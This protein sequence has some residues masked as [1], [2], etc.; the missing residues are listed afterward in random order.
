MLHR[1]SE[2]GEFWQGVSGGVE[3][4]ETLEAAARRELIEETSLR[5]VELRQ[6]NCSYTFAMQEDWKRW[7]APGTAEI[8]EHVFLAVVEGEKPVLSAEEH[9][10]WRWCTYEEAL[11]LLA[12]P[13]N[14]EALRCSQRVLW[15]M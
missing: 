2:R 8:A 12:W 9:D 14:I 15:E 11:A 1:I 4:D 6:V 13:E 10:D 5:P 3:W 7:Y